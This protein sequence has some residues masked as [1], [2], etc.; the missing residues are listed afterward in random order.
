MQFIHSFCF[1]STPNGIRK[2]VG[3][4][5]DDSG[6]YLEVYNGSVKVVI[7]SKVSGSVVNTEVAQANWNL[8]KLDG[9]G[10]SR[11][12]LDIT[13]AQILM[14]DLQWL[15]VGRVRIGFVVNGVTYYVHQFLHANKISTVYMSNA[16]FRW[17][18]ILNPTIAGID[19]ASWSVVPSG[20]I[21]YDISRTISNTLSGGYI[22]ASGYSS[23]KA[24]VAIELVNTMLALG[25]NV[26]GVSDEF[27]LGIQKIGG[28]VDSFIGGISL[29][30][31]E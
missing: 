25:T 8:D 16:N 29:I 4:F 28:G 7:R 30:Q 9:S 5:D 23:Q 27:V 11:A 3:Y 12:T 1:N 14:I 17:A 26:D 15:G 2:R 6:I 10:P 22:V 19:A 21:Q 31:Y 24:A 13:K 18:L 20:S